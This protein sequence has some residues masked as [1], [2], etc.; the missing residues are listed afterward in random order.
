M[1][2]GRTEQAGAFRHHHLAPLQHTTA[3]RA[4]AYLHCCPTTSP[5]RFSFL[6]PTSLFSHMVSS[7]FFSKH[8]ILRPTCPTPPANLVQTCALSSNIV[9]P[10]YPPF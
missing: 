7:P 9:R 5:H 2:V 3:P 1:R 6:C 4:T 8:G 10:T